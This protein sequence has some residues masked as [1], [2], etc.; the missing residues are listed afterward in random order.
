LLEKIKDGTVKK[1]TGKAK[2][3]YIKKHGKPPPDFW[4]NTDTLS[5][6]KRSWGKVYTNLTKNN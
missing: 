5:L 4:P 1:L 2:K 6:K 3:K